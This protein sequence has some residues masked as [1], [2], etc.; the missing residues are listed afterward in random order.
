MYFWKVH[1]LKCN[2]TFH[3]FL[4]NISSYL[5]NFLTTLHSSPPYYRKKGKK[6]I[7]AYLCLGIWI[8][9]FG[10]YLLVLYGFLL[11]QASGH[12]FKVPVSIW[13]IFSSR[14]NW[15]CEQTKTDPVSLYRQ[16]KWQIALMCIVAIRLNLHLTEYC[17]R[18]KERYIGLQ[19]KGE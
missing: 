17:K 8:Y 11:I 4:C 19:A 16:K 14:Q 7:N 9:I 15:T 12:I 3:F 18:V 5:G 13:W 10:Y 1:W 6:V 2:S